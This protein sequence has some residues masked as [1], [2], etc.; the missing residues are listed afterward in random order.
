MKIGTHQNLWDAARRISE[1][2][3]LTWGK[4]EAALNFELG[5]GKYVY[6]HLHIYI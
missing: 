5:W 4:N 3:F 2:V 6:I 1:Q